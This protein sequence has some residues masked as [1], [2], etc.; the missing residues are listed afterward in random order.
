MSL[1]SHFKM[2]L[3]QRTSPGKS[4]AIMLEAKDVPWQRQSNYDWTF[5]Q[6]VFSCNSRAI[7]FGIAAHTAGSPTIPKGIPLGIVCRACL[8]AIPN[9]SIWNRCKQDKSSGNSKA[10]PQQFQSSSESFPKQF[11]SSS[12]AVLKQF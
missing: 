8:A 12:K 10:I 3:R 5:L 1:Y 11:Q 7:G 9:N 2:P 6:D 4:K